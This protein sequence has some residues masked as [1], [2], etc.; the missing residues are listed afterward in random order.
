LSLYLLADG[1]RNNGP[2]KDFSRS[3]G[4]P[5]LLKINKGVKK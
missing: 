2:C 5:D 1:N 4:F 3:Q